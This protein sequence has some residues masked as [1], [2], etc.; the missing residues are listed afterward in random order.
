MFADFEIVVD[1]AVVV[2]DGLPFR[3]SSGWRAPP[4]SVF[5]WIFECDSLV[6]RLVKTLWIEV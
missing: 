1:A 3:D 4:T 2:L 6:D 5:G